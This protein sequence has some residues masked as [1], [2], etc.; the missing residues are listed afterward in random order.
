MVI[1]LPKGV[2]G[3]L[4]NE[5]DS[6]PEGAFETIYRKLPLISAELIH[7]REGF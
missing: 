1:H 7:L 6:T 3:E 4:I 5:G 2:L